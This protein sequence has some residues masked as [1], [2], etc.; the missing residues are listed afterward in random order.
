VR[1]WRSLA[2]G[3]ALAL[4]ISGLLWAAWSGGNLSAVPDYAVFF[5][6]TATFLS[7]VSYV[8]GGRRGLRPTE[9]PRRG[10]F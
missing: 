6:V 10:R 1:V 7:S 9:L 2:R 5:V 4:V 3:C 8:R